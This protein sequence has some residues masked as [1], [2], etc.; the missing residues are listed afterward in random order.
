MNRSIADMTPLEILQKK[1]SHTYAVLHLCIDRNAE[2]VVRNQFLSRC[3]R[4]YQ[5]HQGFRRAFL[6]N[7]LIGFYLGVFI[8][9]LV[10]I[11]L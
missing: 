7:I 11:L 8:S 1:Y 5:S 9:G 3:V 10:F 6:F 4:R 2:L